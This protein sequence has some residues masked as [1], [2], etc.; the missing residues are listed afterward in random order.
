MKEKRKRNRDENLPYP[1]PC[2]SFVRRG[3]VTPFSDDRF[4]S[5]GEIV[6][7]LSSVLL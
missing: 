7:A 2:P 1:L 6:V 5:H 4:L 3:V